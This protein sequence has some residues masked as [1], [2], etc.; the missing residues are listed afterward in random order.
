[1]D[2]ETARR[3]HLAVI[4]KFGSNLK[5]AVKNPKDPQ[6]MLMIENLKNKGIVVDLFLA[7]GRGLDHAWEFYAL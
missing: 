7:S 6:T 3:A 1:M 4:Q 2:E 5:I